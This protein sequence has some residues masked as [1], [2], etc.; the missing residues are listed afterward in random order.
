MPESL[1]LAFRSVLVATRDVVFTE[2]HRVNSRHRGHALTTKHGASIVF[3]TAN[4]A[5]TYSPLI[6]ELYNGPAASQRDA[7]S[8]NLWRDDPHMPPWRKCI[9]WLQ[10]HL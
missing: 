7:E 9:V 10:I 4:Y 1:R 5:D 8:P 2:G 3:H 6:P